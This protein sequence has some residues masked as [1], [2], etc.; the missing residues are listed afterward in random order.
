M[1]A[2]QTSIVLAF[3][4]EGLTVEQI[5]ADRELD[6]IA[7]KAVLMSNCPAYAK[8]CKLAPEEE[9]YLNFSNEQMR[10]VNN[11]IYDT[12]IA[13]ENEELRLKAAIYIRNDKKGRLEPAKVVGNQFNVMVLNEKLQALKGRAEQLKSLVAPQPVTVEVAA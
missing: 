4:Q 7:V 12:A 10:M 11:V 6:V 13:S 2:E 3:E 9:D 5:A 1:T 8:A